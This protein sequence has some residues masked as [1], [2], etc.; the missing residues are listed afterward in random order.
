MLALMMGL[1]PPIFTG[2][3]LLIR[4]QREKNAEIRNSTH[5]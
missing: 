2:I 1:K 3:N 4:V 5:Y